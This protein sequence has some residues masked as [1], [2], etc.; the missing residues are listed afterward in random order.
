MLIQI[1]RRVLEI[2]GREVSY[3]K[4]FRRVCVFFSSKLWI[5]ILIHKF[6]G[7]QL[8]EYVWLMYLA[9]KDRFLNYK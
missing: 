5:V 7:T 1:G 4:N 9:S 8:Y 2:L 6:L 3:G